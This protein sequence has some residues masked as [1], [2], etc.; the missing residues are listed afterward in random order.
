MADQ[1]EKKKRTLQHLD[2]EQVTYKGK[3]SYHQILTGTLYGKNIKNK[4]SSN[5]LKI[6][7]TFKPRI[8]SKSDLEA[9]KAQPI[10]KTCKNSSQALPRASTRE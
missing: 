2:K 1:G 9:Q 8:L 6:F 10:L 7:K 4:K 3:T 5:I